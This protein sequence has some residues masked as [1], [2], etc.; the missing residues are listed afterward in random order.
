MNNQVSAFT[1]HHFIYY[2]IILAFLSFSVLLLTQRMWL[3]GVTSAI[4]C[5]PLFCLAFMLKTK[6]LR[7]NPPELCVWIKISISRHHRWKIWG[8][9]RSDLMMLKHLLWFAPDIELQELTKQAIS[10]KIYQVTNKKSIQNWESWLS[11]YA[12]YVVLK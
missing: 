4:F 7:I 3:Y 6:V 2:P 1:R 8:N 9:R 10:T 12:K 11:G 5:G